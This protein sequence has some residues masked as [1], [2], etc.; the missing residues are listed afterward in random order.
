MTDENKNAIEEIVTEESQ[1]KPDSKGM[2]W[3]G[4]VVLIIIEFELLSDAY[5][6]YDYYGWVID[7]I[8]VGVEA[9]PPPP[10]PPYTNSVTRFV[11]VDASST[12]VTVDATDIVEGA[13]L[14]LD[15]LGL[16]YS[17]VNVRG[18]ADGTI[19]SMTFNLTGATTHNQ[20]ESVAPYYLFGDA[21]GIADPGTL[22]NGAY[23]L[24]ATPW[25]ASGGGGQPGTNLT[26][27][28][29]VTFTP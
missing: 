23:T 15:A 14:D 2:P 28:F 6:D 29:T 5:D 25:S 8:W 3:M 26:V 20:T 21:A 10:P 27:N 1:N 17:N 24:V 12:N 7:D 9:G 18:E 19:G 22:T 11:L 16:V 4:G 13:T